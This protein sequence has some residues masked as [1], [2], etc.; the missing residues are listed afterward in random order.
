VT[1][2]VRSF[3]YD[4]ADPTPSLAGPTLANRKGRGDVRS[5][6]MRNDVLTFD[7]PVF[8]QP[9]EIIGD[10]SV[11]LTTSASRSHHDLFVCLCDVD[12]RGRTINITDAYI[13]LRA[14]SSNGTSRR[15][16]T[17][18]AAPAAWRVPRGHRLR[19]LVAAGAFPRFARNR[20]VD[21]MNGD[22]IGLIPVEITLH[23]ESAQSCTLA[24]ST[25]P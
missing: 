15:C 8:D 7:G 14:P 19:L 22:G 23:C 3:T 12:P 13:R 6:S 25:R 16:T 5:L 18:K 9:I 24:F 2:G 1:V 11:T 21:V 4:P 17:L 10:V 20:G